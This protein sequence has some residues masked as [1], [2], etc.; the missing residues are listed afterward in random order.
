MKVW[1]EG[2]SEKNWAEARQYW[3]TYR[4]QEEHE[5][6][7]YQPTA[8]PLNGHRHVP[9]SKNK[10]I[11][12]EAKS[13]TERAKPFLVIIHVF[14]LLFVSS[15]IFREILLGDRPAWIWN[16]YNRLKHHGNSEV[17]TGIAMYLIAY[18]GLFFFPYYFL[19][20]RF[21]MKYGQDW[22][23]E[24]L[25]DA[26]RVKVGIAW[27]AFSFFCTVIIF[28]EPI[29]VFIRRAANLDGWLVLWA[30]SCFYA[31][32]AGR[33]YLKREIS[34]IYLKIPHRTLIYSKCTACN[35]ESIYPAGDL[36]DK[37]MMM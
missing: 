15:I 2:M 28:L 33:F 20:A 14:I 30:I 29:I 35:S 10:S 5:S 3:E 25:L 36:R 26:R 19:S 11:L 12:G 16:E 32:Y 27:K 6:F 31:V 37:K 34:K 24:G 18:S 1:R 4:N 13:F 8:T 22:R 7:R 9:S 21:W 23:N 17:M